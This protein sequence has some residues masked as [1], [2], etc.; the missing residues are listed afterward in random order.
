MK[1]TIIA[2]VWIKRNYSLTT[3]NT[4]N[5]MLRKISA[6]IIACGFSRLFYMFDIIVFEKS[7]NQRIPDINSAH[8][9]KLNW[10]KFTQQNLFKYALTL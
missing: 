9:H 5:T 4:D 2:N 6:V 1:V 7:E 8:S 10:Q 3:N